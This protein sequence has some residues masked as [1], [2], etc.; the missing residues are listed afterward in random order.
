MESLAGPTGSRRAAA[1]P[2]KEE[3][4]EPF[5][6]HTGIVAPLD[7]PDIDTDQIMPARYL[8][9]VE[10]SGFGQYLFD[11][12]R[13]GPDRTPNAD[14]VL[15]KP[16]YAGATILAAGPNFGC[17]SSREHAPWGLLDYGFRAIVAPS[18]ADIFYN[19]CLQNGL[20]PVVL[21]AADV[22]TIVQRARTTPGYRLTVDLKARR[23]RDEQ[24]LKT[25]F[26]IDRFKRQ[27]L[28]L[29]LDDIDLTLRH[30][31]D[32]FEPERPAWLPKAGPIA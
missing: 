4:V 7:L 23:V 32:A 27:C 21:P 9:R 3:T 19:N 29:G 24:G 22:A 18:F 13:Y 15:N 30:V 2:P 8:K 6:C 11:S 14:F 16:E 17:G 12:W 31:I 5:T 1:R 20:L 28:L 26:P 25:P 10:K